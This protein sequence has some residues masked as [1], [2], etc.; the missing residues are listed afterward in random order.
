MHPKWSYRATLEVPKEHVD[1]TQDRLRTAS[2]C[3]RLMPEEWGEQEMRGDHA[4]EED[5]VV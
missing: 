5:V 3:T 1:E 4:D 2:G